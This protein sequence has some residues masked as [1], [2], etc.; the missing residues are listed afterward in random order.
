MVQMH[1]QKNIK[2]SSRTECSKINHHWLNVL[3]L[4]Y[5]LSI[6][7]LNVWGRGRRRGRVVPVGNLYGSP[8]LGVF[9]EQFTESVHHNMLK[10]E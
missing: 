4:E 9:A 3:P 2:F 7:L 6:G 5:R 10:T 8:T 1:P